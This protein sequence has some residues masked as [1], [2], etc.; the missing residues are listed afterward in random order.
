MGRKRRHFTPEFKAQVVLEILSGR[1]SV[2]VV[3]REHKIAPEVVARWKR[4]FLSQAATVFARPGGPSPAEERIA[5]LEQALG[6][7]T[8]ELEVAK[9]ASNIFRQIDAE[10]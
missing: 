1:K 4:H 9:K 5:E 10:T 8:L 6:R 7:K 2:A 3:C